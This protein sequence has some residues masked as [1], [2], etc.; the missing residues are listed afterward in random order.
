MYPLGKLSP[1][2]LPC[3]RNHP[4][5]Y[6]EARKRIL[7]LFLPSLSPIFPP[8]FGGRKITFGGKLR[9]RRFIKA[10]VSMRLYCPFQG[11]RNRTASN[12]VKKKKKKRIFLRSVIMRKHL[13][14]NTEVGRFYRQNIPRYY[15]WP[16]TVSFAYVWSKLA[17]ITNLWIICKD[18][19]QKL[20]LRKI[21]HI[22]N[23]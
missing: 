15:R 9:G 21:V 8:G 18:S 4:F 2:C 12:I 19:V 16:T 7:R 11:A 5:L 10:W 14:W 20:I 17:A 13:G 23:L 22:T 3:L 6:P 1:V